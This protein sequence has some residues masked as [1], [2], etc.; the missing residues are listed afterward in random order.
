MII[1]WTEAM[2]GY[3]EIDGDIIA[4]DKTKIEFFN[5][6]PREGYIFI[7]LNQLHSLTFPANIG[8]LRDYFFRFSFNYVNRNILEDMN[9]LARQHLAAVKG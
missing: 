6:I 5:R 2:N 9:N 3:A 8:T 7:A 4:L 1:T